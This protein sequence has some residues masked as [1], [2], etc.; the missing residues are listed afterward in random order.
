MLHFALVKHEKYRRPESLAV[1]T[2]YLRA[3]H[4][5]VRMR[6][7]TIQVFIFFPPLSFPV[8]G[9]DGGCA[10]FGRRVKRV[11]VAHVVAVCAANVKRTGDNENG[12]ERRSP[13]ENVRRL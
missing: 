5:F 1:S 8:I 7:R 9:A 4:V 13:A 6:A 3:R 12:T 2:S 11:F 10:M